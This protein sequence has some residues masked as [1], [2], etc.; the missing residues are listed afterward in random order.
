VAPIY[1]FPFFGVL[2]KEAVMR[3]D[4]EQPEDAPEEE[5]ID[6]VSQA[7]A[8]AVNVNLEAIQTQLA[9]VAKAERERAEALGI[10]RKAG[11]DGKLGKRL[12]RAPARDPRDWMPIFLAALRMIPNVRMACEAACVCPRTVYKYRNTESDF[13]EQWEDAEAAGVALLHAAAFKRAVA[14]ELEP[15]YQG[16]VRV[17]LKKVLSDRLLEVLL[18]AHLPAMFRESRQVEMTVT[19]KVKVETVTP[20]EVLDINT[21]LLPRLAK[22]IHGA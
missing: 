4:A 20:Q 17:G 11:K 1:G 18:K 10:L 16:G 14:G 8:A 22:K 2:Q 12:T 5:Q 6:F 15:I 21:A 9:L 3:H 13:K 7:L 19:G